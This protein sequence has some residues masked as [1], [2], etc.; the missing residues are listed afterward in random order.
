MAAAVVAS[1]ASLWVPEGL[2]TRKGYGRAWTLGLALALVY[3]VVRVVF[4]GSLIEQG[5][6]LAVP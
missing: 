6:E 4:G 2:V 1:V 3:E 5:I